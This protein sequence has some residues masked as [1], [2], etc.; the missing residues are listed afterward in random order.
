MEAEEESITLALMKRLSTLKK[1]KEDLA[2][3]VE[4]EEEHL[5]NKLMKRLAMLRRE[6]IE[7]EVQVCLNIF[8]FML[9]SQSA[10]TLSST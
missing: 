2:V 9:T 10:L 6:K 1:E 8:C 7:L 5:T 4:R 3:E